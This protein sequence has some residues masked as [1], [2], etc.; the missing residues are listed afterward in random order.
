LF[1]AALVGAGRT[2][3]QVLVGL[4]PLALVCGLSVG[5]LGWRGLPRPRPG[6]Q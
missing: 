5:V 4:L 6:A 1:A 3:A 2:P